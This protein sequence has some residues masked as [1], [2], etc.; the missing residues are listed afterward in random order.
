MT[1]IP[2]LELENEPD[3][4]LIDKY[5]RE[6]V[7]AAL[8][9]AVSRNPCPAFDSLFE[10]A[11]RLGVYPEPHLAVDWLVKYVASGR[12]IPDAIP[13]WDVASRQFLMGLYERAPDVVTERRATLPQGLRLLANFCAFALAGAPLEPELEK[14]IAKHFLN[15]GPGGFVYQPWVDTSSVALWVER[16]LQSEAFPILRRERLEQLAPY[17]SRE[18]AIGLAVNY[19]AQDFRRVS[20]DVLRRAPLVDVDA[21]N[22]WAPR[23]RSPEGTIALGLWYVRVAPRGTSIPQWVES[24]LLLDL[25]S[26]S[27]DD[28]DV[29]RESMLALDPEIARPLLSRV[30]QEERAMLLVPALLDEELL[31]RFLEAVDAGA[32]ERTLAVAALRHCG[33]AGVDVL[34]SL[35]SREKVG[36]NL[37]AVVATALGELLPLHSTG[38]Q[39][40]QASELLV[41]FLAHSSKTVAQAAKRTLEGLGADALDAL[42]AA[43]PNAKKAVAT[44]IERLLARHELQTTAVS[45]PLDDIERRAGA[46][47]ALRAEFLTL[48][49]QVLAQSEVWGAK[50]RPAIRKH[51]ALCLQWLRPWFAEHVPMGDV[52]LWCY[53][54]EHLADV[55]EAA[56]VAVDT[57]SRMPKLPTSV[58][59]RPRRALS[60]L[61]PHLMA[62]IT[63]V[64]THGRTEYR[65]TLFSLVAERS[66]HTAARVL[67]SA[68]SDDS[69]VLRTH[70]IDGLSRLPD[71]PIDEVLE[72]LRAD[73]PGVRIAVAELLAVWGRPEAKDALLR[74]H[75]LER[76]QSVS[77][78]LEEAL[79]AV[80]VRLWP[81]YGAGQEA[82]LSEFLA[83]RGQ[84]SEAP[85]FL[86]T[87]PLPALTF[88][89]GQPLSEEA[90]LGFLQLVTQLDATLKGRL[91][92]MVS[93]ALEPVALAAW[94]RHLHERWLRSKDSRFKWAVYQLWLLADETTIDE[95]GES[96]GA[97]R[98]ADHVVV[99]CYLRVLQWRASKVSL[100]WLVYWSEALPSRGS[101]LLARTLL[102]RVAYRQQVPVA[103]LRNQADRWIFARAYE[104]KVARSAPKP[105]E[106]E[107]FVRYLE[108]CWLAQRVW[109]YEEWFA[110]CP[111]F[112]D[113]LCDLAWVVVTPA[114]S[115]LAVWLPRPGQFRSQTG[116][117]DANSI[118]AVR[119]AHPLMGAS[120]TW[121]WAMK[122]LAERR[123]HGATQPFPQHQRRV[124]VYETESDLDLAS[125]TTDSERLDRW[126]K[127]R[128]WF[129][130]E[131]LDH[132]I[133]YTNTKRATAIGV[134]FQ[135]S[136]SGYAIGHPDGSERVAILAL[137]A[138]DDE[139]A[140][141]DFA[142]LPPEV[143]SEVC[144]SV[145]DIVTKEE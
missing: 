38:N 109:T 104:R 7:E 65:E 99:A 72:L 59:A 29:T 36:A 110:L 107:R 78:Y 118:T 86:L 35:Q 11:A 141:V 12:G 50:L 102:G 90:A 42:R 140:V 114:S 70:A 103:S 62:P 49:E 10:R 134:T 98:S 91:V 31:A 46:F 53:V 96:I 116:R 132:G 130:G 18:L 100:D 129:H 63:F 131:P 94:S 25:S 145:N 20:I 9:R 58:W 8:L 77:M 2:A 74:A 81:E 19:C 73:N 136:H 5:S 75:A 40:R 138:F 34:L 127:R 135:L 128:G 52:R 41:R 64:L 142:A 95:V 27:S 105:Y 133:V 143:Y 121:G 69:K 68:L 43:L 112:G 55:P 117:I 6:L 84:G 37:A 24:A 80:G 137:E 3:Q 60:R 21:L 119:L 57:F 4:A 33:A 32:I 87:S 15:A 1:R 71:V 66:D 120:K 28:I 54:V 79:A 111:H 97:L 85:R 61:H 76:R 14:L 123:E 82:A 144:L 115:E 83:A 125:L 22:E 139:G 126:L 56:W 124:F 47:E 17:T 89:S 51:G 67:L 30:L 108:G 101:R 26:G 88:R 44:E 39:R 16:L 48:C 13:R 122:W 106:K 113:V 93:K 45:T 23:T 92:R